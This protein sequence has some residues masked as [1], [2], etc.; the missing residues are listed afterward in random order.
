MKCFKL[1]YAV[2]GTVL[3]ASC[4]GEDGE[5]GLP[6][7]DGENG[8]S[9]WDTNNN[10]AADANEDINQDGNFNALDCVGA[11]GETGASG[12]S[13]WD[14]NNNGIADPEEDI[15]QDG[16]FDALDCRGE[17]GDTGDTGETGPPGNANVQ[18]QRYNLDLFGNYSAVGFSYLNFVTTPENY[19]FLYYIKH[20]SGFMYS[21]PGALFSNDYY[22][23]VYQAPDGNSFTVE[24]YNTDDNT[25][26]M[27]PGLEYEYI[28]V[29][30]IELSN[31]SKNSENLMAELK[32]AGVDVNDYNA[33]ATY[34]G[35]E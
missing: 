31:T 14:T 33:V 3:I 2:L 27:I 10:G 7:T 8:I 21:M 4:S 35:L 1:I 6:G 25:S 34:F 19:A 29:V 11:N 32:A 5:N 13:C 20:E 16:N 23:R 26:A 18:Q 28:L 12:T 22:T 17:D 30:A 24:F 9:C 15:N